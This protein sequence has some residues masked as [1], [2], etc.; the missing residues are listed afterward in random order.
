MPEGRPAYY[1]RGRHPVYCSQECR[2]S[3]PPP[4]PHLTPEQ[5]EAL[6][7]AQDGRCAICRC[8]ETAT[9]KRGRVRRLAIDHSHVTGELRGLLCLACNTAIGHMRDDVTRLAAAIVYLGGE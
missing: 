7:A 3:T 9:G 4:P 6:L 5:Y 2:P 8:A 1:R